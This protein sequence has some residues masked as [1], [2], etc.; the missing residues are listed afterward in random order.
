MNYKYL[1]ES[2]NFGDSLS[3]ITLVTEH[4]PFMNLGNSNY[5]IRCSL[6][7]GAY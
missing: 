3:I 1:M 4:V 5:V 2:Y 7:L 6:V